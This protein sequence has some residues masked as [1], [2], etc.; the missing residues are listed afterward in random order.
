MTAPGQ[1]GWSKPVCLRQ[2]DHLPDSVTAVETERAGAHRMTM[3]TKVKKRKTVI[4][5]RLSV[6][7]ERVDAQKTH[8]QI[9]VMVLPKEPVHQN[10]FAIMTECAGLRVLGQLGRITSVCRQQKDHLQDSVN[11]VEMARAGAHQMMIITKAK[12]RKTVIPQLLSAIMVSVDAQKTNHQIQRV[13]V[14]PKEPVHRNKFAIMTDC[15]GLK[16]KT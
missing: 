15:A 12:K 9:R 8:H 16:V 6:M 11:A 14:Q 5:Q 4:P 1:L 3:I 7:M 2:K 13:M 10:K